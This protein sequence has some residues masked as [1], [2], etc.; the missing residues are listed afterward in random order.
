MT[1]TS[2]CGGGGGCQG[3]GGILVLIDTGERLGSAAYFHMNGKVGGLWR[4]DRA[5]VGGAV[6]GCSAPSF[7][8]VYSEVMSESGASAKLGPDGG[9]IFPKN[10]SAAGLLRRY[11]TFHSDA[12][13][14]DDND[15][16]SSFR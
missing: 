5:G 11:P 6:V 1:L 3:T 9:R 10:D 15:G 13:F 8:H 16:K 2:G 7:V 12:D 4:A 14:E